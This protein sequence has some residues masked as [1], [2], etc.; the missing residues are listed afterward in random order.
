MYFIYSVCGWVATIFHVI[1]VIHI[2]VQHN[3]TNLIFTFVA[4]AVTIVLFKVLGAFA[5]RPFDPTLPL[6]Q[7]GVVNVGD[8]SESIPTLILIGLCYIWHFR[9]F[10]G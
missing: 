5:N 10:W 4:D 1:F 7:R 2:H 9:Y 6:D 3:Y 8:V